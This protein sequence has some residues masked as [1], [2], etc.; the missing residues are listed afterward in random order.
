MSFLLELD[1]FMLYFIVKTIK[2]FSILILG[3]VKLSSKESGKFNSLV[4]LKKHF[5]QNEKMMLIRIS[6]L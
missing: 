6:G 3:W 5:I 4:L 2:E 1:Q